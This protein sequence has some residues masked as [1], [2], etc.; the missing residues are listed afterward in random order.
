[1]NATQSQFT[2][3][4]YHVASRGNFENFE[5]G[6]VLLQEYFKWNC[7]KKKADYIE[8]DG[9]KYYPVFDSRNKNSYFH[10]RSFSFY[11]TNEAKTSLIRISDHFSKTKPENHRSQKLNCGYIKSCYWSCLNGDK[12]EFRVPSE[13]YSSVFIAGII[14]FSDFTQN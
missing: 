13:K 11:F 14:N 8:L 2:V 9:V 6:E 10:S 5:K 7:K 3:D 12:F 4:N 1:M